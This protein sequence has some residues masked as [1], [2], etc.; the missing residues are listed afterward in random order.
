M[1]LSKREREV[2]DVV[3]RD[4]PVTAREVWE[5][6]G[7]GSNYSTI[8][9]FLSILHEK[10]HVKFNKV[11]RSYVYSPAKQKQAVAHSALDRL[12]DTFF[13]GSVVNAVSGL[14][15]RKAEDL[16]PDQFKE[17]AELVEEARK[18]AENPNGE[19]SSD[20]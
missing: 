12:V 4:S 5:A 15:G 11:G 17:L 10:G 1:A 16:S 6:L 3:I 13:Q 2:M 7:K 9:R 14:L 18:E 19:D 8:R 20:E